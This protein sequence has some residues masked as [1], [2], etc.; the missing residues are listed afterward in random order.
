MVAL[1]N[2]VDESPHAKSIVDVFLVVLLSEDL[3]KLVSFTAVEASGGVHVLLT[4]VLV[5]RLMICNFD[6]LF[7]SN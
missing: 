2:S 3:V 5:R 4:A 1:H 6:V 7:V